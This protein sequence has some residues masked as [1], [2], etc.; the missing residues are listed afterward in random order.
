MRAGFIGLEEVM[1]E[2]CYS[3]GLEE[4]DYKWLY[5]NKK[6]KRDYA[7]I[8]LSARR[9]DADLDEED[10]EVSVAEM[11][12]NKLVLPNMV[13]GIF[14]VGTLDLYRIAI[15]SRSG[16]KSGFAVDITLTKKDFDAFV[17]LLNKFRERGE[18]NE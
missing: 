15:I 18:K 17:D 4:D 13:V 9:G 10:D 16:L 5:D 14:K 8:I 1:S 2:M 11:R 12:N 3:A 7:Q 6:D